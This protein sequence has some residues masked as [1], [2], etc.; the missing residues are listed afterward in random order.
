MSRRIRSRFTL[1]PFWLG[2]VLVGLAL[3]GQLLGLVGLGARVGPLA[4]GGGTVICHAE[5]PGAADHPPPAHRD[6]AICPLCVAAFQPSVGVPDGPVL[7]AP[8]V[9][10]R[11]TADPVP[12]GLVLPAQ[13][14]AFAQARAPPLLS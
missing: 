9:Q 10:L 13:I 1:V 12:D 5:E 11:W 4:L 6:C 14:P 2:V 7:P 8:S 3:T